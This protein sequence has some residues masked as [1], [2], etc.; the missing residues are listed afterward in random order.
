MKGVK[1]DHD[2]QES[3][4]ELILRE[5]YLCNLEA[6]GIQVIEPEKD[7]VFL[8]LDTDEDF[9][10]FIERLRHMQ[11]YLHYGF[12]YTITTSKSGLPHRHVVVK[13]FE[14]S[15][16][17]RVAVQMALN[18]DPMREFLSVI[19]LINMEKRPIVLFEGEE[20]YDNSLTDN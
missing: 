2:R 13:M 8:D 12:D 1:L 18:S 4:V 11:D 5:E 15:D 17:E 3:Y 6:K 7:E 19:R 20:I 9:H 16:W 10:E 14:M